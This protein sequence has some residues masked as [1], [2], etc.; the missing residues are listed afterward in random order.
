MARRRRGLT[1][2]DRRL[3]EQ[4]AAT[5]TPLR[6]EPTPAAVRRWRHR[7]E[8]RPC[9][10]RAGRL[11]P[12]EPPRVASGPAP[13]PHAALE[14]AS[15]HMDRRR[16]EKLR[17][18]RIEPE[19]RLDLHGMTS[20]RAHAALTGFILDAHAARPAARAGHHR[21]GP[22]RRDARSSRAVTASCATA[23]RTGWR[24]RRWR[25]HPAGRAARTSGTAAPAR[26]TSICAGGAEPRPRP[27]RETAGAI[28]RSA[29]PGTCLL[30]AFAQRRR[31]GLGHRG[32]PACAL[33]AGRNS[34]SSEP[35][36]QQ[37]QW[38]G[39]LRVPIG[40]GDPVLVALDH[41]LY[42]AENERPSRLRR[43]A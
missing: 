27:D 11:R 31:A 8:P 16:F 41:P 42:F 40:P 6:P 9:R 21:Q 19:A 34:V 29:R 28:R 5:A 26:S 38:R 13:D 39:P 17:R 22:G 2:E 30:V 32:R 37:N 25:P 33:R 43:P 35:D 3:W 15:P 20:E 24:R 10:A 12:P 4:V 18:G 1:P 14:R 7:P 36:I 23:C